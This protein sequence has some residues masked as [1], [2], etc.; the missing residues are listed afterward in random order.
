VRK[1]LSFKDSCV[2]S[3][4]QRPRSFDIDTRREP[5]KTRDEQIDRMLGYL[6]LFIIGALGWASDRLG[7]LRAAWPAAAPRPRTPP[8]MGRAKA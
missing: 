6:G 1:R 2:A 7:E 4:L 3:V 5:M 8:T